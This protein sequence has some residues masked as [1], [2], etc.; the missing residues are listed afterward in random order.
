MAAA[1]LVALA[2]LLL[3]NNNFLVLLVFENGCLNAGA[4]DERSAKASVGTLTDH[5][6]LVDVNRVTGFG[7]W[8]GVDLEDITF[9]NSELAALCFDS[10]FHWKSGR[11]KRLKRE[12]QGVFLYFQCFLGAISGVILKSPAEAG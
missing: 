9:A 8:V 3:K 4:L 12:N 2:T 11:A 5:E 7:A 1:L 10:G 6:D